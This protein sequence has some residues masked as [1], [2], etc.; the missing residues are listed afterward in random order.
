MMKKQINGTP[1]YQKYLKDRKKEAFNIHFLQIFLLVAFLIFWEVGAQLGFID[2]FLFSKPSAVWNILV[3]YVSNGEIFKHL[4]ISLYETIVGLIIGT[5]SGLF[6]AICLWWSEKLA[7]IFDP[8]LVVLN[9]LP[10]TALAPILIVWVG[11]GVKGIVVISIITSIAVTILSAYNYFSTVDEDK[12]KLMKS[13]G[14]SKFQILTKIVLPSNT[15]N[16]INLL[17]INIGM[18][19]V[20]VI[21]G[22]F[23]ASRAGLGYLIVYGGQVFNLSL[24]MMG[25]LVLAICTLL[26]YQLLGY[27]EKKLK[28]RQGANK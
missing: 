20:G 16:I 14:A 13:F 27:Y 18:V 28:K 24:V 10:K 22:E 23:I 8:F 25:I 4:G 26:M 21:V 7:K 2:D 5:C 12:I 15:S 17:K 3:K 6:I 9:A 1:G 19:W 11:T